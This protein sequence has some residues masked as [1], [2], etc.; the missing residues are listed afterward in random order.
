MQ[1]LIKCILL[2]IIILFFIP[3][4]LT[5]ST[6]DEFEIDFFSAP[7]HTRIV[8]FLERPVEWNTVKSK[9]PKKLVVDINNV[10]KTPL[11]RKIRVQDGIVRDIIFY[12][13]NTNKVRLRISLFKPAQCKVLNLKTF[14]K[15]HSRIS[16]N[17]TR[18]DLIEK[19]IKKRQRFKKFQEKGFKLVVI[20][21][22]HG[23]IDPG[24]IGHNGTREKDVV[25]ELSKELQTVLNNIKGLKAAL[26]R[27]QDYFLYLKERIEIAREYGADLFISIHSD[28]AINRNIN[29]TSIY[30]LSLK[31]ASNKGAKILAEKENLS[32]FIG[33]VSIGQEN[34]DLRS[35]LLDLVQTK[36]I[37]DSL[38]FA[39]LA[40]K[41]LSNVNTIKY[42]I[43]HQAAF[44][45]LQSPDIPSVLIEAAY[46]S[47]THEERLLKNKKFQH[48]FARSLS[49][50]IIE[51]LSMDSL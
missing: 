7:D 18:A 44:I 21:P 49:K 6:A 37:N 23:G 12:R 29:G 17:I 51:Y 9:D 22:G 41:E 42:N 47:N 16:I 20:D 11:K 14:S 4:F 50:T 31:G 13:V 30:C 33:E 28:S 19:E 46:L 45:V 32:D 48:D 25:L 2:T 34:N 40:L 5:S 36:T 24:A 39:G 10:D 35:I 8:L 26:T 43:P 27:S 3:N 1:R 38:R 15:L